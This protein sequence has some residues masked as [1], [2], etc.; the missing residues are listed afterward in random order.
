MHAGAPGDQKA[1]VPGNWN[2]SLWGA[3]WVL[4]KS[5]KCSEGSN[6]LC[7]PAQLNYFIIVSIIIAGD[8]IQGFVHAKQAPDTIPL[9]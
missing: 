8:W 7:S 5:D 1:S 6:R 2:C 9:A 4:C 3:T